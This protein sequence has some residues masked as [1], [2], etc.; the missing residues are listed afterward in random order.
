MAT[1]KQAHRARERHSA[2]LLKAG[3]HAITV[4]R[5]GTGRGRG[6]GVI[7]YFDRKVPPLPDSLAVDSAQG[8]AKVPLEA[9]VAARASLE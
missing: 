9:R 5:V 4:D 6:F 7:A 8:A 2:Y 1:E 3:A